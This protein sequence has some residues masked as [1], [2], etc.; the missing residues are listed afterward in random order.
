MSTRHAVIAGLVMT[1]AALIYAWVLYPELPELI[2]IHW[3][4]R[5]QVDGWGHKQWAIY[6]MPGTMALFIGMLYA[7]P[8]LS[9]GSFA[10]DPFRDT[11]NYL[12]VVCMVL[13]GYLHVLMLQAA[14]H[15][16]MDT[17]RLLISGLFLFFALIGNVLGKVRRNFWMGVRTPWTLASDKVWI[18]THRLAARLMVGAGMIGALG[19]WLGVPPALC[20]GLLMGALFVP[21]VYSYFLHQRLEEEERA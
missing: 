17:A 20:F 6:L 19:V 13:F 15:P 3:N 8:W 18:A 9:P 12:M 14:L 11:F 21:V 2:P 10:L 7:L 1:A 5:G 16:E 4:L